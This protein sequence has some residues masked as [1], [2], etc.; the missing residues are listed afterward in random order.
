ML[1]LSLKQWSSTCGALWGSKDPFAGVE[2]QIT[3]HIRY[4]QFITIALRIFLWLGVT[5]TLGTMLKGRLRT[6]VLE[7]FCMLV[8]FPL[9]W[10]VFISEENATQHLP[11]Y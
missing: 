3:L 2:Y 8:S 11:L 10:K 4:L 5:T 1:Y 7:H 9:R 6:I